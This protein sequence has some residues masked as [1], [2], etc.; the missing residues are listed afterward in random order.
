M[1][2]AVERER[3]AGPVA[4][5]SLPTDVVVTIDVDTGFDVEAVVLHGV[6][7]CWPSEHVLVACVVCRF[8]EPHGPQAP[9]SCSAI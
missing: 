9:P 8:V 7:N 1:A 2:E 3:W 6:A 5:E 4:A